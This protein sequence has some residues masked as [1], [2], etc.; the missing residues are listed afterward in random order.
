M[1]SKLEQIYV[2]DGFPVI[3]ITQAEV[4]QFCAPSAAACYT[5]VSRNFTDC[6]VSC[7]GLYADVQF[8]ED[9][10]LNMGT[11]LGRLPF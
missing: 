9:Q 7:I 4:P 2:R 5:A 10:I 11:N 3:L 8:T 6:G 1:L